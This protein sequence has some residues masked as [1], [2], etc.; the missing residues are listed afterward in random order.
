MLGPWFGGQR[1]GGVGQLFGLTKLPPELEAK[2]LSDMASG[3]YGQWQDTFRSRFGEA[4]NLNDPQYDYRAAWQ[5]G[6]VPQPYAPDQNFPHWPST[7]PTGQ[8]LKAPDHPTVWMQHFMERFGVDPN[9][10][11]AP[12]INQ[13]RQ[14]GI[15]PEGWG[16]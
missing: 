13:G 3:P 12:I 2:F 4:P 8:P 10:A 6:I 9:L 15:V 5:A 1:G 11:P 16:R 14:E 7:T